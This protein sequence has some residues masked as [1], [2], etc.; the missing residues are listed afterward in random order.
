MFRLEQ[1]LTESQLFLV[2]QSELDREDKPE[3]ELVIRAL[4]TN[5]NQPPDP[6]SLLHLNIQL[7]DINDNNPIFDRDVYKVNFDPPFGL[8]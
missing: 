6:N 4:D 1:N 8:D 5:T 2:V 3:Y 7:V